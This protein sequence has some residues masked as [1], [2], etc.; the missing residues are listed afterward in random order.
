MIYLFDHL[1]LFQERRVTDKK[2]ER[3]L[4]ECVNRDRR[5]TIHHFTDKKKKNFDMNPGWEIRNRWIRYFWFEGTANKVSRIRIYIWIQL[6]V[7]F[8]IL[9]FC[10]RVYS[11]LARES[12]HF[13]I[14]CLNL[15]SE[16]NPLSIGVFGVQRRNLVACTPR[17]IRIALSR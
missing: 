13:V 11:C 15:E 2:R 9:P 14:K 5:C 12:I 17:I 3:K 4:K 10:A 7:C 16:W 6:F 1:T 8:V